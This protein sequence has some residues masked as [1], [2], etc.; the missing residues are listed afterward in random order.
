MHGVGVYR[1]SVCA[2]CDKP[3][4]ALRLVLRPVQL[5]G[6]RLPGPVEQ[7]RGAPE[8]AGRRGRRCAAWWE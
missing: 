8:P 5:A 3:R 2:V 1:H 7:T 6:G 4:E